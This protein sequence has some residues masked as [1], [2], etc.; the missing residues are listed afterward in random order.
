[1]TF[2]RAH[3]AAA[4]TMAVATAAASSLALVG[5]TR[6]DDTQSGAQ[7]GS[8]WVPGTTLP[9]ANSRS[10]E[11]SS[12]SASTLTFASSS[13]EPTKIFVL[14]SGSSDASSSRAAAGMASSTAARTP[15]CPTAP[16]LATRCARAGLWPKS[17]RLTG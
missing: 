10:V 12:V 9:L 16:T 6:A 2:P 4:L 1:M 3:L 13:D 14:S 8:S 15:T 11:A 7:S 17:P 5:T